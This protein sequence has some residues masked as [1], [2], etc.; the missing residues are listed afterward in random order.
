MPVPVRTI[1]SGF[2]EV[3]SGTVN[4]ADCSPVAV[5]VKMAVMWQML[6]DGMVEFEQ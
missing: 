3:L 1:E 5:G 6:P 4:V 2:V